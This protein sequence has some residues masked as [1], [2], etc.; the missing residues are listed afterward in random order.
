MNIDL[1]KNLTLFAGLPDDRLAWLL[2]HADDIT[3]QRGEVLMEEG[4]PP[5]A[6]YVIVEGDVEVVK[7][8][9]NQDVVIAVRGAG[10]MLGEISLI[11]G[12]ARTA[13]V[14]ALRDGRL[15]RVSRALF[16]DL[17]CGNVATAMTI[18]R[19]I[20]AR[21]RN[22][23]SM[24]AQNEK[25]ASLG[26]LAAGLAHELNN[27]A[28]A[29][30]R[31]A[32]QLS[33]AIS[34]WLAA[35][36]ALDALQLEPALNEIVV[37]RLRDDLA[38]NAASPL[39]PDPLTRSDQEYEIENWLDA[40]G[41][42][43]AYEYAPA[44]AAFG[45]DAAALDQWSTQFAPDQAPVVLC[46]LAAG[47]LVHS[48]LD[49]V[50]IS[51]ER[52]SEIV[53][54]IKDYSYLDQAPLMEIDVHAGLES[55]LMILKHKLKQGVNVTREY[56]GTLPRI[57]AFAS[58]L[59]QVWT[60]IIDNAIDAMKGQG[61]LRIRTHAANDQVVVEIVDSG[62]GIPPATLP[63]IFEPFFTTKG[64]GAGTGLGL[65]VSYN[66]V[67]KHRGKIEVRSRPGET[68]FIVTLPA[69]IR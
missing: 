24:L 5:D 43:A 58:E 45:W 14:R 29:T 32:S 54:A 38:R 55:T 35:R 8:S 39:A 44:L 28:A 63:H 41:V 13:T 60:N 30:R 56:D 11:G 53:K 34:N 12:A 33:Q 10:E 52:I 51:A 17:L 36:G 1:L 37:C 65:H 42:D 9:N 22:T 25:L 31:S 21:L 19:T 66:I 23:E 2:E 47:Y 67:Q 49:E 15:I 50:N 6:F 46:W 4:S 68:R 40:R 57:Q 27:P 64:P 16:E 61:E 26:T 62:P 59:N 18:L 20:I 7:H 69:R 3:M 48:L